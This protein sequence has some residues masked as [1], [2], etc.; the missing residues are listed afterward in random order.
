M[1]SKSLSEL[2]VRWAEICV[3]V[4]GFRFHFDEGTG[5]Y[6]RGSRVANGQLK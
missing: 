5:N 4:R 1:K 3:S 2:L 6:I